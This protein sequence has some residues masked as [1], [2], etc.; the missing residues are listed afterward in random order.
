M[1]DEFGVKER[2]E[3]DRN[4]S[5]GKTNVTVKG[6]QVGREKSVWRGSK[7]NYELGRSSIK[8]KQN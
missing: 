5:A 7:L 2:Q 6:E 4:A 8:K 3:R 1:S